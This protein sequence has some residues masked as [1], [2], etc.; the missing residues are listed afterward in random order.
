MNAEHSLSVD[1]SNSIH[2]SS[3][4]PSGSRLI[5]SWLTVLS[6]LV[7][8]LIIWGGIVRLS[9]S[10]LSIPEWP[11]I[12]GS[13]LPP[14]T[15]SDWDAV[16]H[17]Y[18]QQIHGITDPAANGGMEIGT[19][20]VMFSI[21]YIHRLL[22]AIVSI[23]FLA[24]FIRSKRLKLVWPKV[25]T[26][27]IVSAVLL[28]LQAV[29]GG[30]VVKTDLKAEMVAFHLG[31]GFAF[32][33]LL[34]WTAM[35]LG[36]DGDARAEGRGRLR[37]LGWLASGMA[38]AQ[39]VTGGLVAGTGAGLFL[40]TW[41]LMGDYLVPP[42]GMLFSEKMILVQFIH[43]WLAFVVAVHVILLVVKALPASLTS[44]GRIALRAVGTMLV[45]Q[46]LLGIGNLVMKV[47][48]WMSLAHLTVGLALFATCLVITHEVSYARAESHS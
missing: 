31:A 2:T 19:F 29:L 45:L 36:H 10:G 3:V 48:F 22:A 43:R 15:D 41:P 30:I 40:N 27:L 24:V 20:K 25:K 1:V 34:L 33:G 44:R 18:Y 5:A 12:N 11:I 7:M 9:G 6:V 35:R 47:P 21:E 39:I 16:Y 8:V 14:L 26:A 13:L 28:L 17:T 4:S 42:L 38:W 46:I 37:R 23:V 32:F